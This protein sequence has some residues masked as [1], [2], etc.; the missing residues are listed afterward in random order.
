MSGN[1]RKLKSSQQLLEEYKRSKK[2]VAGAFG[3]FSDF[4][5]L[6]YHNHA[7]QLHVLGF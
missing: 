2:G 3:K 4:K 7:A 5:V 1:K 6:I